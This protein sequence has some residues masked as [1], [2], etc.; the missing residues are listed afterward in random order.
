MFF[1]SK[2][3]AH[4]MR[5]VFGIVG[6][7]AEEMHGDLTQEQVN[8]PF[9]RAIIHLLLDFDTVCKVTD[10]GALVHSVFGLCSCSATVQATS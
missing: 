10:N 6:T 7:K 1:R 4:Q 8:D 9:L 2:K 3:L 5:V